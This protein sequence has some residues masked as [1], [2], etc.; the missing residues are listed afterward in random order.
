[1]YWAPVTSGAMCDRKVHPLTV[2]GESTRRRVIP[3]AAAATDPRLPAAPAGPTISPGDHPPMNG[4]D[5]ELWVTVRAGLPRRV[6]LACVI[7][8]LPAGGRCRSHPAAGWASQVHRRWEVSDDHGRVPG[9]GLVGT[10]GRCRQ[11]VGRFI[12]S[13]AS[14]ASFAAARVVGASSSAPSRGAPLELRFR[15][16]RT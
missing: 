4:H 9:R 5:D 7:P 6:D 16:S 13:A 12:R 8:T 3:A 11:C 1:M 10:G 2:S 15:T 14:V